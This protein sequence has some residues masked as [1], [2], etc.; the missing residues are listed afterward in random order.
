VSK[1]PKPVKEAFGKVPHGCSQCFAI[2][3]REHWPTSR[4]TMSGFSPWCPTCHAAHAHGSTPIA[5]RPGP[6]PKRK[7]GKGGGW[8]NLPIL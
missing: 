2:F 6:K 7:D 4:W 8:T 1:R 3:D 5:N